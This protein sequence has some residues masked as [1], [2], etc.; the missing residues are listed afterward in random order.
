[1]LNF[2]IKTLDNVVFNFEDLTEYYKQVKSQYQYLKWVPKPELGYKNVYSWAIQTNLENTDIPAAPYNLPGEWLGV[3][4]RKINNTKFNTPTKLIFGFAEQVLKAFPSAKHFV[5]ITHGAGFIIPPHIDDA[6][7]QDEDHI[8]IHVP[9][10][11]NDQSYFEFGDEKFVMKPGK[12][13]LV[14][15][16]LEHSTI[17]S[18]TT[19]RAH[20]IFKIPVSEFDQICSQTFDLRSFT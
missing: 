11:S 5:L 10:E 3:E 12:F 8:K 1:M 20:L 4:Q 18:G 2:K 6:E 17:N 16:M 7:G 14:N 19:E 9:I 15:T 13:Y